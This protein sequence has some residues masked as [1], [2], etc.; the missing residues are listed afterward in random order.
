MARGRVRERMRP[1]AILKLHSFRAL[2]T[3][4][5]SPPFVPT[6]IHFHFGLRYFIRNFAESIKE[7]WQKS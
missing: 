6:F 7:K 2:Q 1:R 5:S 4:L 3:H